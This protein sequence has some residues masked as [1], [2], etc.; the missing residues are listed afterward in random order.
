MNPTSTDKTDKK[1]EELSKAGHDLAA[2]GGIT[3]LLHPFKR[4]QAARELAKASHAKNSRRHRGAGK[5][6]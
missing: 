4:S 2:K 5:K 1:E 3:A 6:H